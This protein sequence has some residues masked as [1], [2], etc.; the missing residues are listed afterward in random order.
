MICDTCIN[1]VMKTYRN[2]TQDPYTVRICCL[3]CSTS[4]PQLRE[5][6][7]FVELVKEEPLQSEPVVEPTIIP[8]DTVIKRKP[9]NPNWR[10]HGT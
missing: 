4:N 10:K 7:R 9:G 8:I 3:D 1:V 5:C 6:S 2:G